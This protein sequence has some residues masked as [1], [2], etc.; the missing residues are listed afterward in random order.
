ML[1][2]VA[3]VD[4]RNE[5]TFNLWLRM[6]F[7]LCNLTYSGHLTNRVK[8]ALGGRSPPARKERLDSNP[9]VKHTG[10]GVP[11]PKDLDFFSNKG[12]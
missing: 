2:L 8:S 10:L 9:N 5:L 3:S 12:F 11:I 6:T 4:Y 7:C 1:T